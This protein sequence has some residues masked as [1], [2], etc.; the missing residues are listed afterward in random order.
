M[1]IQKILQPIMQ[2]VA[3]KSTKRS[4]VRS[5]EG[6]DLDQRARP[7]A[8]PGFTP[9]STEGKARLGQITRQGDLHVRTLLILETR[10]VLRAAARRLIDLVAV[11]CHQS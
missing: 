2:K 10:A 9:H 3:I 4:A 5:S 6:N 1:V 11:H 7:G 8:T